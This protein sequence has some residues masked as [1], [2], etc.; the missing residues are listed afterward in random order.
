MTPPA[1]AWGLVHKPET[2]DQ[3]WG[4]RKGGRQ[5]HRREHERD[6][7]RHIKRKIE[8]DDHTERW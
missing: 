8:T 2:G 6:R 7:K 3:A 1:E 5:R 4:E